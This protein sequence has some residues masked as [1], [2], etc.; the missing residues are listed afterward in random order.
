MA[1]AAV[2]FVVGEQPDAADQRLIETTRRALAAGIAAA[3]PGSGSATSRNAIG[4]VLTGAGFR[5]NTEFGGHGVGTTMHQ[6]PH[7][8]NNGRPAA[9]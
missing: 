6:D 1:D 5:V 7:V 3:V 8:P 9:A 2:S 4:T